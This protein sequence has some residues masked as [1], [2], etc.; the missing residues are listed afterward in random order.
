MYKSATRG[1]SYQGDT[2][3]LHSV[4]QRDSCVQSAKPTYSVNFPHLA[5]VDQ[6][7]GQES[8]RQ[9]CITWLSVFPSFLLDYIAVS[10]LLLQLSPPGSYSVI[11]QMLLATV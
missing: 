8:T 2:L 7:Q 3:P 5:P 1:T 9:F 6:R 11:F 10:G 4:D